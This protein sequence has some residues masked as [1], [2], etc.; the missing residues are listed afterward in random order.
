MS[1]DP[2]VGRAQ[3]GNRDYYWQ[4]YYL[5]QDQP[6]SLFIGYDPI[7]IF[8]PKDVRERRF[9]SA[10]STYSAL[11]QRPTLTASAVRA[12]STGRPDGPY[13]S[14][15]PSSQRL[16]RLSDEIAGNASTPFEKLW[17]IV[18]HLRQHHTYDV[19]AQ[20]QLQLS[21]S[22]EEFLMD[23]S[24][25]TSLDFASATVMLARAAGIP[26]QMAVGYL[27]GKFDPFSGTH[28]VRGR[29]THAWAE[30]YF[31]RHGWVAFDAAPRPE[32]E[33]FT[34]GNFRGFGGTTF[35]F[36]NR[37]GG[38][39]YHILQSGS[40]KAAER[41]ASILEGQ[42]RLIGPAAAIAAALVLGGMAY[43]TLRRRSRRMK[44]AW[45]YSRLSGE[46]RGEVLRIYKGMERL[47]RR[48]GLQSRRGS[49]TLREYV[50]SAADR[51]EGMWPE[52]EWITKAA[53]VAAY[54]PSAP[55][56]GLAQQAAE[57]LSR[58]RRG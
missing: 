22:F 48:R 12:D 20:N 23:G 4:A 42:G 40:V 16:R 25:G 15:P 32:L 27:P 30:V 13:L 6:G 54:N 18:S 49:Q 17:L 7:R 52:I 28:V 45:R 50:E 31:A 38:G 36:H 37:V 34:S 21:K 10:G 35:V 56:R 46:G 26:A 33:V 43:W 47:L 5:E 3:P 58:L 24:A 9:L 39:L 57:Q 53:W 8:L 41:I 14:L 2:V 29:D 19:S 55:G 1:T 11:S 51:F 44:Q